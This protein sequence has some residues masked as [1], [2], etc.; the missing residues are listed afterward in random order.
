M[1]YLGR[2][3]GKPVGQAGLA[4]APYAGPTTVQGCGQ[5]PQQARSTAVDGQRVQRGGAQTQGRSAALR[6]PVAEGRSAGDADKTACRWPPTT[7][8]TRLIW[9][10]RSQKVAPSEFS[11][12]ALAAGL[13]SERVMREV[14]ACLPSCLEAR[15]W[16][17]SRPLMCSWLGTRTLWRRTTRP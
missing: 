2:A 14:M 17:T 1:G 13:A 16:A 3:S 11:T 12:T 5:V 9:S 6:G 15:S 4:H 8:R 7:T 10:R